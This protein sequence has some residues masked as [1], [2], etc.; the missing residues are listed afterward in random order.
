MR[1]LIES[2]HIFYY[3]EILKAQ[4]LT[5]HPA[6]PDAD[7][8]ESR[9]SFWG[10]FSFRTIGGVDVF[11]FGSPPEDPANASKLSYSNLAIDM[12]FQLPAGGASGVR[13]FTFNTSLVSF[14]LGQSQARQGSLFDGL[15]LALSGID[16]GSADRTPA[17]AGYLPVLTPFENAG[18]LDTRWFGIAYAVNL[19]TLGALAAQAGF[20]ARLLTAWSP[21]GE[22]PRVGVL[23][24]L[25]GTA[26]GKQELS[27]QNVL[28][29]AIGQIRLPRADDGEQAFQLVLSNIGLSFLGK[30]LP[31]G[32]FM[33]LA[34]FGD[35]AN[36]KDGGNLG[37]YGVWQKSAS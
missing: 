4:F 17:A 5:L 6:T 21:G 30:T 31:S 11:S 8:I 33:E 9:F 35:P 24:Q 18:G 28:K 25:P 12:H 10:H 3:V 13:S 16:E 20:T 7:T 26:V 27:L 22:A 29:L 23:M 2:S 14:D 36:Q 15:P 19:G 1:F 34:L 37:W 32:A